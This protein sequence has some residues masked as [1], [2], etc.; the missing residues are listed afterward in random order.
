MDFFKTYIVAFIVFLIID[1]LWLGVISKELYNKELGFLLKDSPNFIAAGIFYAFFIVGVVFFVV[2]PALAKESLKYA[3]LAGLFL[4]ALT[5]ATY[6]LTN[7][8]TIKD[9]PLKIVIIDIAW[10]SFLT[11][12][13][14]TISYLIIK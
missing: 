2:N 1:A 11:M 9:W 7:L 8:A 10:G 13:V 3:V 5:Y 6:D 12:A 4:G 14:S